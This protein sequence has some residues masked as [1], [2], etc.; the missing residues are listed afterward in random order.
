[1]EFVRLIDD[2]Q[3]LGLLVDSGKMLL[4]K[5]LQSSWCAFTA[6]M[7]TSLIGMEACGGAFVARA[8]RAQTMM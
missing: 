2:L 3:P 1:M 7:Q 6:N 5:K 4:K 8:L